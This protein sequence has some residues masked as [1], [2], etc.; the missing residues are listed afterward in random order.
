MAAANPAAWTGKKARRNRFRR[1]P[2]FVVSL[3][4]AESAPMPG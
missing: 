1:A 4:R 3:V 2:G